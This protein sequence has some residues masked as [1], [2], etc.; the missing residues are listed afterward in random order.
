MPAGSCHRSSSADC[1]QAVKKWVD[2]RRARIVTMVDEDNIEYAGLNFLAFAALSVVSSLAL[3]TGFEVSGVTIADKSNPFSGVH[4][5]LAA[6][7]G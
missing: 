4:G 5:V 7:W 1:G 6:S 2:Q 3:F